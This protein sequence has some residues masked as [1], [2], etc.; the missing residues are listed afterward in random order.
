MS[1]R[2][3]RL[4]IASAAMWL[5]GFADLA[6]A[7]T[8]AEDA[9]KSNN[10]LNPSPS[11]NFQDY[12]SPSLYGSDAYTNDFLVRGTLPLA[13]MGFIKVPQLLRATLPI[14]TR[15]SPNGGYTTG[16]GDLN[17]FDIFLTKAGAFE[18]GVGPLLTIPTAGNDQL[19][20]GKWQAGV[21]AVAV[22]PSPAGIVGGL[23]QWQHS[24]A[25]DS[26]RPTVQSLTVQPFAIYN[27]PHGWY[28]RSTGIWTFDLE[29][30]TYYI[31]IGL[32]AG[33]VWKAGTTLMNL[34][35]EPQW[36]VSHDG[37]GYPK[38]TV[39]AGLNLTLGK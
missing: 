26:D 15:P 25:G 18:V 33:K 19:G 5:A 38:F 6:L 31:P 32:G 16:L 21:A 27:L 39:F 34:F 11:L 17:I 4:V 7:Q 28:L 29:R 2:L 14:S 37:N 22:H 8:S 12:Y 3:K 36:T 30:H 9:N 24:F 23:V 13:P 1:N 20:T 10:P 35:V